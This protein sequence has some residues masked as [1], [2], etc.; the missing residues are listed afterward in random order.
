MTDWESRAR[1]D[2]AEYWSERAALPDE[3][4]AALDPTGSRWKNEL[5]HALH[6]R[7]IRPHIRKSDDVL[8]FGCGTGRLM[9]ELAPSVQS[10]TGV[11][12]SDVMVERARMHGTAVA[13]DGRTLPFE[14]GSFDAVVSAFV[15]QMYRD[16]HDRFVA[17]VAEIRRVLTSDGRVV[18]VERVEPGSPDFGIEAWRRDIHEAGMRLIRHAPVRAGASRLDSMLLASGLPISR[19]VVAITATA[20]RLGG[21]RRPYTD[22]LLLLEKQER[23]DQPGGREELGTERDQVPLRS[24]HVGSQSRPTKR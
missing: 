21:I 4:A 9:R 1:A 22:T 23:G 2:S 5:I 14:N 20:H 16:Q 19:P 11:D 12:I 24:E 10:V 18:M 17:L 6:A 3:L 7:A 15:L 13:Y 8:D